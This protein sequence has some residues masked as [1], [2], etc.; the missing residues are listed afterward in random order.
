MIACHPFLIPIDRSATFPWRKIAEPARVQYPPHLRV[1]LSSTSCCLPLPSRTGAS[2]PAPFVIVLS[3]EQGSFHMNVILLWNGITGW[4]FC[5][6]KLVNLQP[7]PKRSVD[8]PSVLLVEYARAHCRLEDLVESVD[9]T[10]RTLSQSRGATRRESCGTSG[11]GA[12]G[13][14]VMYIRCPQE[15]NCTLGAGARGDCILVAVTRAQRRAATCGQVKHVDAS[16]LFLSVTWNLNSLKRSKA[17][18]RA[19]FVTRWTR[20]GRF[21][22]KRS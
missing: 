5:C 20:R 3:D 2:A 18:G 22:I 9:Q 4:A 13:Q 15:W 7:E 10:G 1:P 14:V 6:D 21:R 11:T 19:P 12:Q 17:L 8:R 16:E